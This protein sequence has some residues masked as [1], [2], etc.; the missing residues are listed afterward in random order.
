MTT[1]NETSTPATDAV[2]PAVA[3]DAGLAGAIAFEWIK[4]RT[5]RSTW[6]SLL[7]GLAVIA[8]IGVI[9]GL[10]MTASGDNG[11][12]ISRP[13]PHAA[14][15]G[16]LLAQLPFIAVATLAV[17]SEY[18]TRSI[19]TTL[20][21]VPRRGRMLLAKIAVVTATSFVSG[22]ALCLLGT[23]A[24]APFAGAYGDFTTRDLVLTSLAAGYFLVAMELLALGLGTLLRSAAGTITAVTVLLLAVPQLL[25]VSTVD[26]LSDASDYLPDTAGNVLFT[27]SSDPYGVTT[28]AAVLLA[29]ASVAI[30]AGYHRLRSHD[31]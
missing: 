16:I 3:R 19:T 30:L 5:V 7:S 10:S 21:S 27:Q 1:S 29:W 25:R 13:A 6:W 18:A 23:A 31:A 14:M 9:L 26:W 11:F 8:G 12:D 2:A 22:T 17:T 28:A 20:Q 24:V 15:E 4:L